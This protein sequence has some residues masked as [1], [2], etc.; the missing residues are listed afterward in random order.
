MK[1]RELLYELYYCSMFKVSYLN[2]AE[3][4]KRRSDSHML[5]GIRQI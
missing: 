3:C 1:N 4:F 2:F 5:L